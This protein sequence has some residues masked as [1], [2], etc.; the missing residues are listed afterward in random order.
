MEEDKEPRSKN[1]VRTREL[2]WPI[3]S[4]DHYTQKAFLRIKDN[5]HAKGQHKNI[6]NTINRV[7]LDIYSTNPLACYNVISKHWL[8]TS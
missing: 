8:G 1:G 6:C 3:R 7:D 5:I 4:Y 2:I